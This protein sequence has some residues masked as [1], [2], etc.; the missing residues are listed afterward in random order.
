MINK[1]VVLL[2][3]VLTATVAVPGDAEAQGSCPPAVVVSEGGMFSQP[4]AFFKGLVENALIAHGIQPATRTRAEIDLILNEI[5]NQQSGIFTREIRSVTP[6]GVC[7]IMFINLLMRQD[8]YSYYYAGYS[9]SGTTLSIAASMNLFSVETGQKMAGATG[10][11]T[12]NIPSSAYTPRGSLPIA[13]LLAGQGDR[14]Q[15]A[16]RDLASELAD[17]AIPFLR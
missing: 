6:R 3:A 14:V 8:Y 13:I 11:R 5:R 7:S 17:R 10:S 9:L 2:L 15:F 12:V 4:A 16:M 1:T